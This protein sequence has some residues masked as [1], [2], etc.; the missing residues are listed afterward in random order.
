MHALLL[1]LRLSN[2]ETRIVA[3]LRLG[4]VILRDHIFQ[5]GLVV[6]RN[7]LHGFLVIKVPVVMLTTVWQIMSLPDRHNYIWHNFD[8]PLKLW[9]LNLLQ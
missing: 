7:G 9:P 4:S 2:D 6:E 3:R 8:I 5:C 1:S